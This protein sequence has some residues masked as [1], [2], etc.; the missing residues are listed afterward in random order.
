MNNDA[1][2]LAVDDELMKLVSNSDDISTQYVIFDSCSDDLYGINVA[3]VVELLP[4]RDDIKLSFNKDKSSVAIAIGKIRDEYLILVDFEKWIGKPSD[5]NKYNIILICEYGNKRFGIIIKKVEGI[6]NISP[7]ELHH[8][9]LSSQDDAHYVTEVSFKDGSLCTIFDSD[10]LLLDLFPALSGEYAN[11]IDNVD[12]NKDINK[13]ILV[14]EDSSLMQM[15]MKKLFDKMNLKYKFFV[16]GVDFLE[17]IK[18]IDPEDIAL[19]VTDVEMPKMDGI[20]LIKNLV[21]IEKFNKIKIIVNTNMSNKSISTE[22]IEQ[23]AVEVVKKLDLKR[24]EEEILKY[25]I[26]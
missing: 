1:R 12:S 6:V 23:G 16:N 7:T 19:I 20:A 13:L 11:L 26:R 8:S 15:H 24:L 14:A 4:F 10:R 25:A 18:K 3:K 9:Q 22:A 17:G 21:K 5:S 2:A